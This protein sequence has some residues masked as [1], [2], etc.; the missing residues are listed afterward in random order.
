MQ[1]IKMD[2]IICLLMNCIV[3]ASSFLLTFRVLRIYDFIDSLICCFIVYLSQ[4]VISE[5]ILG[6]L[7][8]LYLREVI[9]LNLIILLIAILFAGRCPSVL[10]PEITSA[11]ATVRE[12]MGN[13]LILFIISIIF[14]F[15]LVKTFINLLNPPFGWDSLNYHF[16]FP[17]EWLKH[18]NLSTPITVFDDPSPSYYPLNG[19]LYYLW[20]ML[21][22]RNVFLA[23]LGQVPFFVL[24]FMALYS[25]SKKIGLNKELSFYAASLFI[26]IPNFF[27]QL[28]IAY[29][30]VM[31]AGL[32]LASL[33]SLLLLSGSFTL[34]NLLFY[35]LSMGLLIGTKTIALPYSI[36]LLAPFLYL[37]LKN[38]K[39]AYFCLFLILIIFVLGG[40]SYTRNF[41]DTGNPL[42]PLDF[43]LLGKNIFKGVMDIKTYSVHFRI[44]DYRLDK[45]LFHEGLGVQS[46]I[47]ILPAV[48]LTLP[49]ALIKRKKLGFILIYLFVLPVLIYL[50][51]RFVIPLANSRYLYP[52]LGVGIIL[53]FYLL[54]I[55]NTP[56]PSLN[57]LVIICALSSMF[58]LA[59]RQ[60]LVVSTII[61]FLIF[62][63]SLYLFRNIKL[64]D[65]KISPQFLL[66]LVFVVSC[67]LI[68]LEPA[69]VKNEFAGYTKMVKYSGFWPDATRAWEWL[70]SHTT[71]NNIAYV[72]RPVPFP[73]YGSNFKN[74]VYYVSV[75]KTE[76]A[77]LHYFPSSFYRWGHDFESLHKNLEEKGNYREN[78]DYSVWLANLF[79]R[80]T[81]YFF[82]YSLHQ[83]KEVKFSVEDSWAKAVPSRFNTVFTN[84]TIHI[85]KIIR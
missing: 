61:T 46:L 21:P 52:L 34:R 28:Q 11:R 22:L 82:V 23:D 72:G 85:Y 26:L 56:K 8:I 70:N 29:V 19:S 30:D 7:G 58:Q 31:V 9:I 18:G 2:V 41:L 68:F 42:Y 39:K 3:L 59:K 84:N 43:N 5:L 65:A 76:P 62:S 20:L 24:A 81:D 83:T 17:V 53:G 1:E 33:N 49:V 38:T 27:K 45:L 74:N 35:G 64:K 15:G 44:E 37:V 13:K 66:R 47:I 57:I 69:Y 77:K 80:N 40:F 55:L 78:P 10:K 36:L 67:G 79:K 16:T 12:F 14:C 51:Y 50:V 63:L 71:G 73:L 75:N 6:I 60:E 32:F 48:L 4:I 54:R 25:I